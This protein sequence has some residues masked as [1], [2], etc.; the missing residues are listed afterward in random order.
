MKPGVNFAEP[1][2]LDTGIDLGRRDRGVAEHLLD[3]RRSAPPA[4]RWVAKLCLRVCGLMSACKPAAWAWRLTIC[5]RAIRDNGR[6]DFET[7]TSAVPG[8]RATRAGRSRSQVEG[9]CPDGVRAQGDLPFLVSLADAS[10]RSH[11]EVEVDRPEPDDFRGTAAGRVQ[12]FEGRAVAT[13]QPRLAGRRFEQTRRPRRDRAPSAGGPRPRG[14]SAAWPRCPAGGPRRPGN[15][16]RST[17][18]P[19]AGT[20][21]EGAS[22]DRESDST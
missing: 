2:E 21:C 18:S 15:G 17:G 7:N 22:P 12:G 8:R 3:T 14:R 4:S 9:E 20:R 5:Q 6:P 19:G 16:R 11:L 13:A 10:G 1:A